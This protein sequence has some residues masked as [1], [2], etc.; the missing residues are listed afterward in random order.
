MHLRSGFGHD[1]TFKGN[2]FEI[3]LFAVSEGRKIWTMDS[4]TLSP[5]LQVMQAIRN[6]TVSSA[7]MGGISSDVRGV[8]TS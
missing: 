6:L 1:L 8:Y 3:D 5:S 4:L 7:L 2:L